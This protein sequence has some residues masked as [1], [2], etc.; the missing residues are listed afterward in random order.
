MFYRLSK[1]LEFRKNTP[2]H[3]V[4][5][6]LFSVFGC[7]D[8]TLSLVFDV[9]FQKR[10]RVFH[11]G[12]QTQKNWW[13]HEA[14]GRGAF[15]VFECLETPM[16]HEAQIAS[17]SCIINQEQ[18]KKFSLI[19]ASYAE[20]KLLLF[21]LFFSNYWLLLSNI[22]AVSQAPEDRH[23]LKRNTHTSLNLNTVILNEIWRWQWLHHP[24]KVKAL[25][26]VSGRS[27]DRI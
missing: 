27:S 2:L 8:E 10:V 26:F 18:W 22:L 6:T 9:I 15:I 20:Y 7:P 24:R 23:C 21:I 16:K 5:S 12:F 14:V 1:L 11:R 17:Q 4:F 13:K 25:F 3:V 19:L